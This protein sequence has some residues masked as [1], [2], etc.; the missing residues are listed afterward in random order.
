MVELSAFNT[1]IDCSGVT[2]GLVFSNL[3]T[4]NQL[5]LTCPAGDEIDSSTL[6]QYLCRTCPSVCKNTSVILLSWVPLLLQVDR[7][8]YMVES[9]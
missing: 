9:G 8:C 7:S 6:G 1:S 3:S 2:G 4:Y 5:E